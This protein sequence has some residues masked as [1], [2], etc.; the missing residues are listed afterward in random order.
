[1]VGLDLSSNSRTTP[2]FSETPEFYPSKIHQPHLL[3]PRILDFQPYFLS[4]TRCFQPRHAL[5]RCRHLHSAAARSSSAGLPSLDCHPTGGGIRLWCQ[6]RSSKLQGSSLKSTQTSLWSTD[7]HSVRW[8]IWWTWWSDF[9]MDYGIIHITYIYIYIYTDDDNMKLW[10]WYW[11]YWRIPMG[12]RIGSR[13]KSMVE[14]RLLLL[15]S[16]VSYSGCGTFGVLLLALC[17]A[18]VNLRLNGLV[19]ERKL[20][21]KLSSLLEKQDGSREPRKPHVFLDHILVETLLEVLL[22]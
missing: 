3:L 20:Q 15:P 18:N 10:W 2:K 8:K 22:E 13:E 14:T 7:E 4:I 19:W 5:Q 16:Q 12:K 1:M 21:L 11:D 6:T 9:G 17:L